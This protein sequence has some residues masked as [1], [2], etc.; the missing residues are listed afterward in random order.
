MCLVCVIMVNQT[1]WLPVKRILKSKFN[2]SRPKAI[3]KNENVNIYIMLIKWGGFSSFGKVGCVSTIAATSLE[4]SRSLCMW[5]LLAVSLLSHQFTSW[6]RLCLPL[7]NS[8]MFKEIKLAY[9]D[10]DDVDFHSIT[11]NTIDKF[12][13]VLIGLGGLL[14]VCYDDN[15]SSLKN[16]TYLCCMKQDT[17]LQTVIWYEL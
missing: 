9:N 5:C 8:T 16:A 14:D 12:P 17:V 11:R 2:N 4:V 13:E 6:Q 15:L 7:N 3:Q 10:N 1:Y